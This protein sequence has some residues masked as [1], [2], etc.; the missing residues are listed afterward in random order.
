MKTNP[1]CKSPGCIL[2]SL[3]THDKKYSKKETKKQREL[4]LDREQYIRDEIND[5][6]G[7]E[8]IQEYRRAKGEIE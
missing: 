2:I 7:M 3:H 6:G 8:L 1:H 5:K 4:R